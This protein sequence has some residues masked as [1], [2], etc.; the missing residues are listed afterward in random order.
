MYFSEP[1]DDS[2]TATLERYFTNVDQPVFGLINLPEVVKAALFARYSRTSK[3]IRRLFLDEFVIEPDLGVEA[4][5]QV[6]SPASGKVGKERA[7]RLFDKVFTEFGDDSVAQLGGAHLACEQ[8]SNLLTKILERGRVASYLE[9]STRYISYDKKLGGRYRYHIPQE[10]ADGELVDRYIEFMDELF[11]TYS[12]MNR[13][14]MRSLSKR[15]PTSQ[16]KSDKELMAGIRAEAYDLTRGLLPAATLSN[17]GIYASGQAYENLLI[18]MGASRIQE[19]VQYSHMMLQ[20][21]RKVIPQFL[22]RVDV[23]NRG[24][25]TSSYLRTLDDGLIG[26]VSGSEH[27]PNLLGESSAKVNLVEWESDGE[28]RVIASSL[29]PHSDSSYEELLKRVSAL[30]QDE[31]S[32]I[33]QQAV[34]KRSNRRHK[35]GRG[36]ESTYYTFD[37]VC[38]Y[39]A[40]RDLQRH[41]LLSIDWQSLG[42]SNGY[43]TPPLIQE[44]GEG[45]RWRESMSRASELF[46]DIKKDHGKDAAQYVVPFATNVRFRIQLNARAAFHMIE[47]RTGKAGHSSYRTVCQEMHR[48]IE[49][50]ANHKGIAAA[51]RYVDHNH[52]ELGRVS[53]ERNSN[54]KRRLLDKV[55]SDDTTQLGLFR[56]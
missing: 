21:L 7:E 6:S 54:R 27:Q 24:V 18:R 5:A 19:S 13:S 4:I 48:A 33:I 15:H 44:L 23:K 25:A 22:T 31:K 40:F 26:E 12:E 51:M 36:F 10:L 8:A 55:K 32:R 45:G 53:A 34:G 2:Q 9:Q 16:G 46:V 37:I 1:F 49:N 39:G 56:N 11:T 17:L 50:V 35:P 3:S 29:Y 42:F 30:S 20:E 38:D 52:Y 14:L 28:D 41:R 43:Q 47:L